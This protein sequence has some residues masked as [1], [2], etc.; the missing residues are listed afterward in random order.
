[1]LLKP[2]DV[3]TATFAGAVETKRR[4]AVVLSSETY[5]TLRPDVIAGLITTQTHKLIATDYVLQDWQ[6]AGLREAS[7]FRSYIVTLVPTTH[8]HR[9]GYL[10]K[11]DWHGICERMRLSLAPFDNINN[12]P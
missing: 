10:T 7:I 5:H 4:P 8:I 2:G 11:Q 3:V 6:E 1:M 9:I 12:Q